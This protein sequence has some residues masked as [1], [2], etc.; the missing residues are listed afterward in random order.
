M[1]PLLRKI[2][3]NG[4]SEGITLPKGWLDCIEKETGQRPTEVAIE[5]NGILKVAP[6]LEK[7]VVA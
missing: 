5:V 2:Y 1:C 6:V 3:R 7:T 4:D